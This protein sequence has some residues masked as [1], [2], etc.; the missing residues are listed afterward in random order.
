MMTNKTC[1]G[2][3]PPPKS[4]S[5]WSQGHDNY[6]NHQCH[7]QI[8]TLLAKGQQ[9]EQCTKR[10]IR[11]KGARRET[12]YNDINIASNEN[13]R[14]SIRSMLNRVST[15]ASSSSPSPS[16]SIIITIA[17]QT[18]LLGFLAGGC[19][20]AWGGGSSPSKVRSCRHRWRIRGSRLASLC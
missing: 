13:C 7:H 1:R 12:I 2:F 6:E 10:C 19:C 18:D 3:S 16:S 4:S 9:C 8:L 20:G 5:W 17:P 11:G 15:Y 14:N